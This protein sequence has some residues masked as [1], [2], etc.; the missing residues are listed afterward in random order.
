MAA[1]AQ[2]GSDADQSGLHG[3]A[4]GARMIAHDG[5][6]AKHDCKVE[7]Q[8]RTVLGLGK[9][10]LLVDVVKDIDQHGAGRLRIF[11]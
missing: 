1:I 3:L 7:C 5:C 11:G 8:Q 2:P 9:A 10:E 6:Y 4:H